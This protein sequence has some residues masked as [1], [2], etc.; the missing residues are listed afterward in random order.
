MINKLAIIYKICINIDFKNYVYIGH[1]FDYEKTKKDILC[2]LQN[3][4][5]HNDKLQNKF[6]EAT[7][8]TDLIGL[9]IQ[10]KTLQSLRTELYPTNILP[11]VMNELEKDF[12]NKSKNNNSNKEILLN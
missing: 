12:I 4:R 6:N 3:N 11:I 5:F 7:K 8:D 9:A 1:T 2:K 10:F